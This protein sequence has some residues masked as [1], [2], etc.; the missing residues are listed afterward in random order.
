[1]GRQRSNENPSNQR[2]TNYCPRNQERALSECCSEEPDEDTCA[3]CLNFNGYATKKSLAQGLI[4][5]AL[6]SANGSK[7]RALMIFK[8]HHEFYT[9]L[10]ALL[11]VSLCLQVFETIVV[12]RI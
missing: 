4:D 12:Q 11:V 7:L 2:N 3:L 1:M 5:V 6:F 8:A 9:T 10:L